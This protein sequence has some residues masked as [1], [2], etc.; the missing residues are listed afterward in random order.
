MVRPAKNT[1]PEAKAVVD[2]GKVTEKPETRSAG[3]Q[4]AQ[5]RLDIGW[6]QESWV[7]TIGEES[8]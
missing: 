1:L 2:D 5:S 8:R 7:D 6:F 3:E 4:L